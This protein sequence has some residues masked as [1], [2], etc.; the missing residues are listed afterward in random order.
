[1]ERPCSLRALRNG[2]AW[3]DSRGSHLD[4]PQRARIV[5]IGPKRRNDPWFE[6][7][8][9]VRPVPFQPGFQARNPI[10][11]SGSH[12]QVR[13]RIQ[14]R[15]RPIVLLGARRRF[16][17]LMRRF[18]RGLP[19]G[20][21]GRVHLDRASSWRR[22]LRAVRM[23]DPS[24][25]RPDGKSTRGNRG[26]FLSRPLLGTP[27]QRSPCRSGQAWLRPCRLGPSWRTAATAGRALGVD[28]RGE[29]RRPSPNPQLVHVVAI[30][31]FHEET[32]VR[33]WINQ[34]PT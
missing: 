29:R 11:E 26:H 13:L 8:A 30:A 6:A 34:G 28:V 10:V 32:S 24:R 7:S 3:P 16:R 20:S 14:R 31:V 2:S 22:A 25:G 21:N 19:V 18:H 4:G 17:P 12:P 27:L 15:T 33:I 23:T 9:G 5:D 1:M